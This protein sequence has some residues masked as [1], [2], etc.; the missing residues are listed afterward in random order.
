MVAWLTRRRGEREACGHARGH[1]QIRRV[2]ERRGC[3]HGDEL[4]RIA[5][6]GGVACGAG[7]GLED[8]CVQPQRLLAEAEPTQRVECAEVGARIARADERVVRTAE[9]GVVRARECRSDQDHLPLLQDGVGRWSCPKSPHQRL[10]PSVEA[11][12]REHEHAYQRAGH[13]GW[14]IAQRGVQQLATWRMRGMRMHW[15]RRR[16]RWGRGR[17]RGRDAQTLAQ[18][19]SGHRRSHVVGRCEWRHSTPRSKSKLDV[20]TVSV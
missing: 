18:T 16:G 14:R 9:L 8:A 13:L 12:Q 3:S 19:P 10:D 4:G 17:W 20:H 2:S 5:T 11:E 7:P 6:G 1:R 15:R